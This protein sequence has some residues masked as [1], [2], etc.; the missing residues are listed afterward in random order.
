MIQ[1][2]PSILINAVVVLG[3]LSLFLLGF[4][5]ICDEIIQRFK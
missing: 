4:I 3:L 5:I 2:L 1:E